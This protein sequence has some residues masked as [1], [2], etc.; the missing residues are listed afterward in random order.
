MLKCK[1]N[2]RSKNWEESFVYMALSG[3][4]KFKLFCKDSESFEENALIPLDG[5]SVIINKY[6]KLNKKEIF[7]FLTGRKDKIKKY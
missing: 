1:A 6:K 7:L 3:K 5:R 2:I 4:N